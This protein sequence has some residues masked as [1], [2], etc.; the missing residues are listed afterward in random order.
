[1]MRF[2]RTLLCGA[3]LFICTSLAVGQRADISKEAIKV[4]IKLDRKEFQLGEEIVFRVIISN[5]G[6][7]PF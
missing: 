5:V 3:A 4:Q 6:T 1:M 2:Q 7:L